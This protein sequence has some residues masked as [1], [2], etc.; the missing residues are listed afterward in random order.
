MRR[1][2]VFGGIFALLFSVAA[3]AT[4]TTMT[5]VNIVDA[6]DD[7][8]SVADLSTA[9][10]GPNGYPVTPSG[11]EYEAYQATSAAADATG[12]AAYFSRTIFDF[13][14]AYLIGTDMAESPLSAQ[15]AA[16]Y[17][18]AQAIHSWDAFLEAEASTPH[19]IILIHP[20][21]ADAVDSAWL[22]EAYRNRVLIVGM[23]IPFARLAELVGDQCMRDPNP[24]IDQ[25]FEYTVLYFT[26]DITLNQPE[27]R[28]TATRRVLELC[29]GLSGLEGA[30]PTHGSY[31][32]G[33]F[34][35]TTLE[36]LRGNLLVDTVNYGLV[37]PSR[38]SIALPDA[39]ATIQS[40]ELRG[41]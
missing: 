24:G 41:N 34:D 40:P 16:L 31:N 18:G 19:Q 14:V 15:N 32:Q 9:T 21:M 4:V 13:N 7:G 17:L 2:L 23:D 25:W 39:P 29:E 6:Q 33:V 20:T 5:P 27:H 35:A 30:W 37:P 10:P 28:E 12:E 38:Q 11:D 3:L 26:F 22:A 36:E 1:S 8:G